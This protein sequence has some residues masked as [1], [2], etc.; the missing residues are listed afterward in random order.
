MTLPPLTD[1]LAMKPTLISRR[2]MAR[3]NW[4]IFV[5][6]IVGFLVACAFF[7][8]EP[9]RHGALLDYVTNVVPLFF[10]V[11]ATA[12]LSV[13][14]L[15][16]WLVRRKLP[17]AVGSLSVVAENLV[18]GVGQAVQQQASAAETHFQ[19]AVREAAIWYV[20][21]AARRWTFQAA[22][23]LLIGFGGIFG[24]ILLMR[25]II[26]MKEQN[27]KLETQIVL[28]REQTKKLEEQTMASEAQRRASLGAELFAL[29]QV[30]TSRQSDPTFVARVVTLTRAA[31]P[32][33]YVRLDTVQ[34]QDEGK[35]RPAPT[36]TEVPL[37]PERG[38]LLL[39]LL[40]LRLD[41]APLFQAGALFDAAD[42]A[43]HDLRGA[44]LTGIRLAGADLRRSLLSRAILTGA[45]LSTADFRGAVLREVRMSHATLTGA[46]LAGIDLSGSFLTDTHMVGANLAGSILHS[47]DLSR[48]DLRLADLRGADLT[49]ANLEEVQLNGTIV[50]SRLIENALPSEF[51]R[52]LT[53]VPDNYT[54]V[55][56]NGEVRLVLR[57]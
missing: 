53:S 31:T 16:V 6:V 25:Q 27:Q 56:A 34:G 22:L 4:G 57:N 39:G 48:A 17:E 2:S 15:A 50:G 12:L 35:L 45:D 49:S 33:H 55:Q 13:S 14:G 36:L 54:L 43:G 5:G 46:N 52:G 38:L 20:N 44:Q 29:L 23:A 7:L 3:T 40:S 21:G 11:M 10:A 18:A 26:L 42:L 9:E 8:V 32:F 28:I 41:L 37:S 51:P 1:K 30:E 19:T 24:T 47:V